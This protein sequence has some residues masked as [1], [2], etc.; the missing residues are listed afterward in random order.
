MGDPRQAA[1]EFEMEERLATLCRMTREMLE[2]M[3]PAERDRMMQ[4]HLASARGPEGNLARLCEM[5]RT[6]LALR[7]QPL[8][9]E[10][11]GETDGD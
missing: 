11:K 3:T 2:R 1:R 10:T 9:S 8:G 4:E 6:L 5:T 7:R